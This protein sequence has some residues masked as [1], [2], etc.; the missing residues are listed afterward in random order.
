[1]KSCLKDVFAE[2]KIYNAYTKNSIINSPCFNSAIY[3]L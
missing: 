1:M 3:H 2:H